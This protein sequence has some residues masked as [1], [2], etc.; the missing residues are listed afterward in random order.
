MLSTTQSFIRGVAVKELKSKYHI[1]KNPTL[2]AHMFA[3]L[4][5]VVTQIKVLNSN[6][7]IGGV[8]NSWNLKELWCKETRYR[9]SS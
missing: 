4:Q 6:P 9:K 1:P 8:E 2:T 3:Y 7:L 5:N